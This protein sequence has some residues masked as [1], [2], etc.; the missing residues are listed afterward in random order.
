MPGRR[1][2]P[3]LIGLAGDVGSSLIGI[4]MTI[5]SNDLTKVIG[6]YHGQIILFLPSQLAFSIVVF[7]VLE[8]P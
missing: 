3:P 4:N 5:G 8:T 1:Q 7:P 6:L 2:E